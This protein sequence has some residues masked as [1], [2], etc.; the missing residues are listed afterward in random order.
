[1]SWYNSLSRYMS[2]A[3]NYTINTF[4]TSSQQITQASYRASVAQEPLSNIATDT[5]GIARDAYNG[6]SVLGGLCQGLNA[7]HNTKVIP[8]YVTTAHLAA[9]TVAH[10]PGAL[11]SLGSAAASI[12]TP[13]VGFMATNPATVTGGIVG[14]TLAYNNMG[15]IVETVRYVGNT[16][17]NTVYLGYEGVRGAANVLG[18][19]ALKAAEVFADQDVIDNNNVSETRYEFNKTTFKVTEENPNKNEGVS[20]QEGV[21]SE[22]DF[23][24]KVAKFDAEVEEYNENHK[25]DDQFTEKKKYNALKGVVK[26]THSFEIIPDTQ[27]GRD[28]KLIDRDVEKFVDLKTVLVAKQVD[29]DNGQIEEGASEMMTKYDFEVISLSTKDASTNENPKVTAT[30]GFADALNAAFERGDVFSDAMEEALGA[31]PAPK[32]DELNNEKFD[33]AGDLSEDFGFEVM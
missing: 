3:A 19:T 14:G 21:F 26:K 9:G 15:A 27:E 31:D 17:F 10:A 16:T 25:N 7:F 12:T 32:G 22:S 20:I 5:A 2:T 33:L 24:A 4:G 29:E 18:A 8:G 13:A 1:M 30:D 28:Q 11:G 6:I 23:K